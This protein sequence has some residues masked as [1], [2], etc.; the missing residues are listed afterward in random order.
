MSTIQNET[1]RII[2]LC[3]L[4]R[5]GDD[6]A[7]S[8]IINYCY[9][10]KKIDKDLDLKHEF[11]LRKIRPKLSDHFESMKDKKKKRRWFLK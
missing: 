2:E 4:V 5:E 1:D 11:Q 6:K 3:Y 7:I 10:I 8:T 9:L